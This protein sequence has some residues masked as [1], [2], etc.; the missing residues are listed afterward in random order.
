VLGGQTR[1]DACG[2]P[3]RVQHDDE[4]GHCPD[5]RGDGDHE[6]Q[7]AVDGTVVPSG[8]GKASGSP[9]LSPEQG[10]L[11][12]NPTR[13]RFELVPEDLSGDGPIAFFA[14]PLCR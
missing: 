2:L 14:G 10:Q 8:F 6:A 11:R 7:G 13:E 5:D 1:A 4:D 9:A 12:V 3:S